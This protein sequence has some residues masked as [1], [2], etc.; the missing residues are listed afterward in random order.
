M[1]ILENNDPLKAIIC[2]FE[3]SGTTLVSE[4][5]RQHPQLDSGFEGGFLLN[6]T[7]EAF[8]KTEPFYTNAKVGWGISDE[9]LTY[10]TAVDN[11]PELY[12]RLRERAKVITNKETSLFDKTPRYMQKLPH[13]LE[14]VPNIPCI[15]I[16]KD[17]RSVFWSS[18]KRTK[19]TI[20]EW[21]QKIFRITCNHNLS[22]AKAL[23]EAID[24]SL[25]KRILLIK[26]EELCLNPKNEVK[27]IFDFVGL[28]FQKSYLDLNNPKY[29]NI[30]GSQISSQYLIEYQDNLPAYICEEIL[31]LTSEY[32][33]FLWYEQ[34]ADNF[35]KLQVPSQ[36]SFELEFNSDLHDENIKKQNSK[37]LALNILNS[38]KSTVSLE[39]IQTIH[40]AYWKPG[41]GSISSQEAMFLQEGIEKHKPQNFL[42]IGT[43]S[44]LS[45]GFIAIFMNKNNSNAELFTM[46]L[47]ET[48][49]ADRSQLTGFLAEKI[50]PNSN[51]SINYVRNVDST[52]IQNLFQDKKIDM[53]FIDA[54]HQHP[55]PTL[56]MISIL[57][58]MKKGSLI[59]HH[60]LAL[61]KHQTPIY[62]IG[63][64]YLFDQI[65]DSLKVVTSQS[66]KNIYY[67][68]TPDNYLEFTKSLMDSLY[69]PWTI[70]IKIPEDTLKKYRDIAKRY[71][72]D[73]LL[74]VL[75][76][77]I[78]KFN[79]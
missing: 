68:I 12:E 45:T 39:D 79:H 42:E 71:W 44:G 19:M 51:I 72:G 16:V 23:Q 35:K 25:E 18:Y 33:E 6:E 22:Y 13:V 54:N 26:Y 14:Q 76:N 9:D 38:S 43:A 60:D 52:Q 2:G 48:F 36:I 73:D 21:Y 27:K 17:I 40:K 31:E 32:S 62:G 28:E 61:Y 66:E 55:W 37:N 24:K 10:I 46:D 11:W 57:P 3:H 70:R 69:L 7:A 53:A 49:W 75:E 15:V 67:V 56:D 78:K 74:I 50:C 77:T 59:Y 47:D 1:K 65:P 34:Q 30:Y 64:K 29:K 58:F 63:P 8:L 4:I 41:Y 20:D 5:L